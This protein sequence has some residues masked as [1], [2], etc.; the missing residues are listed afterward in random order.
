MTAFWSA[1]VN[2]AILSALLT[3]AVWI[4][5]RLTP[6][7]TLNAATR[8]AI[9]WIVLLATLALPLSFVQWPNRISAPIYSH[10]IPQ[11]EPEPALPVAAPAVAPS[12]AL[13]LEIPASPWLR[14]LLFAWIGTA[15]LLLLRV[16]LSYAALY[17]RTARAADVPSELRARLGV[18]RPRTRIALSE[19]IAIPMAVGPFRPAILIPAK[20]FATMTESDLDQIGLHEAT[21]LARRD[22]YMLFV[23]RIVEALFALHPVVRWITRQL[24]LEREIAC[25]DAVARSADSARSYADCLTRMVQACG[26]VRP[27]LAA[28]NVA[29]SRSHLSRRVELLVRANRSGSPRL[30]QRSFALIASVLLCAA[31]LLAK[32]PRLVAFATP[33]VAVPLV[34]Q[35]RVEV[36]RPPPVEQPVVVAQ[37]T[38]PAPPPPPEPPPQPPPPPPQ[39][40]PLPLYVLGANDVVGVT[41][42]NDNTVSGT[43]KI[44][45]DGRLSLPLIDDFSVVGL[46]IPQLQ[47]LIT[48]KLDPFFNNPVVN[49]QLLRNN[50]K[51]FT[52]IGAIERPGPYPLLQQTT[53]LDA[54]DASGGFKDLANLK[55]VILRRNDKEFRFSYRDVVQGIHLEQNI[56]LEDGDIIIVPEPELPQD[57]KS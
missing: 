11:T 10:A 15:L 44:G 30:R 24:D 8:Y 7:R 36:H 27:S 45:P 49:V 18:Y 53:I 55:Q 41:V 56:K 12:R 37:T 50:S 48:Q 28:A 2:G 34:A 29:D 21:H 13:P 31:A 40:P 5:L 42:F 38:R 57:K 54:L 20:L 6:R 43:Y 25:D 52:L 46:T 47:L 16:A 26:R 51:K 32:T 4:V 1:I 17:R 19:E 9:W 14:P 22:D 3:I 33:R 23:Q 39:A 35:L